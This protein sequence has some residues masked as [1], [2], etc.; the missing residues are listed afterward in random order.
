M[1]II[2]STSDVLLALSMTVGRGRAARTVAELAVLEPDDRVVDVGCGPGTAVRE[3]AGRSATVTGVDPSP[4]ALQLGRLINRVRQVHN[5]VF[6]QGAAEALPL[7][8]DSATVLWSLSS[9]HHWN[10]R[11]LGVR[12]VHRVLETGGRLLL[13]ERLIKP[14]A[15][16]HGAHGLTRESA[17]ELAAGVERAGFRN[18]NIQER[19]AG[20][21]QLVIVCGLA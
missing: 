11:T 14:S 21:R 18:V 10:D 20:R 12:E 4:P 19:T 2:Q 6:C 8:D 1:S 5:V 3:A 16:G 9:V 7:P 13:A 17:K 15:R